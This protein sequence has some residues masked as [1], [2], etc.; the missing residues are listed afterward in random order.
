MKNDSPVKLLLSSREAAAA[1]SVCER[2]LWTLADEGQI[3]RVRIGKSVRYRVQD[4]EHW[5]STRVEKPGDCGQ[6][7]DRAERT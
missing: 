3:P 4:L 6:T 1:L 2:T 5:I 7:V